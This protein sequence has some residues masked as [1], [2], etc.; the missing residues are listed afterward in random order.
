M[1][2]QNRLKL[3]KFIFPTSFVGEIVLNAHVIKQYSDVQ[4]KVL[5]FL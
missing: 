2:L 3:R 1:Q 5:M 4:S